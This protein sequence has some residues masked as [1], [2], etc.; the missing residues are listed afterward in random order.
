MCRVGDA[1]GLWRV[2]VRRDEVEWV[3]TNSS[4]SLPSRV[5]QV[6]IRILPTRCRCRGDVP[7]SRSRRWVRARSP[8]KICPNHPTAARA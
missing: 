1:G 4:F 7:E 5:R 2:V 3:K 6:I 8:T